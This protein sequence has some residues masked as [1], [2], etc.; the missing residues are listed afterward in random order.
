MQNTAQLEDRYGRQADTVFSQAGT[1]MI[2]AVSES[3]MAKRRCGG[4]GKAGPV[5]FLASMIATTSGVRKIFENR[6]CSRPRFKGSRTSWVFC[7][8]PSDQGPGLH[9][10]LVRLPYLP[11]VQR[12]AALIERVI[13]RIERTV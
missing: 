1:K 10:V 13:P 7:R 6:Y 3:K 9:E 8:R 11:P 4:I 2:F 12:H 5:R